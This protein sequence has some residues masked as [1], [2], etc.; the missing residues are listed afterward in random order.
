MPLARDIDTA[1]GT[2]HLDADDLRQIGLFGGLDEELLTYLSD[3]LPVCPL[4]V[5][6][7]LFREGERGRELFVV[8][9]GELEVQKR[10]RGGRDATL[11]KLGSGDW[12]GDMALID[13]MARP[14]TVRAL[15]PTRVL[16]ICPQHLDA[17]YRRDVKGYALLVMNIARQLSRRLRHAEVVLADTVA[18]VA[19]HYSG[20]ADGKG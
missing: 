12:C 11:A 3:T 8:V 7:T 2:V 15:K 9:D 10:S 17:I 19:D 4:E 18:T 16:R 5:G 20:H 1:G 14:V 13:V 6:A